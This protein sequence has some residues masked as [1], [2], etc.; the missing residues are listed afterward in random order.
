VVNELT[1]LV[2]IHVL[3]AVFTETLP[4]GSTNKEALEATTSRGLEILALVDE[5]KSL[6]GI[7]ERN[8]VMSG[9]LVAATP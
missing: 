8:R 6:V 1:I 2:S 3:A 9:L 4:A 7:I 5:N